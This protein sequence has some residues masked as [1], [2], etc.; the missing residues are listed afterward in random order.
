[1]AITRGKCFASH[2][3]SSAQAFTVR[4]QPCLWSVSLQNDMS[5][6]LM[7]VSELRSPRDLLFTL[8]ITCGYGQPQWNDVDNEQCCRQLTC[9]VSHYCRQLFAPFT[10]V[11]TAGV[12]QNEGD[13][14][15]AQ[16]WTKT[17]HKL[18]FD[19]IVL[20]HPIRVVL[21]NVLIPLL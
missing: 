13:A 3:I 19:L 18:H 7:N 11:K 10:R 5:P 12:E 16:W 14:S 15:F 1:M 20:L 6:G 21:R 9:V 17:I 2:K 4:G 8:Q